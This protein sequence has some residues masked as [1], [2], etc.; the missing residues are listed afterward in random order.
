MVPVSIPK[1]MLASRLTRYLWLFSALLT[2]PLLSTSTAHRAFLPPASRSYRI[3]PL[4]PCFLLIPA[5]LVVS[6]L[7]I[8]LPLFLPL[9][10]LLA[11][12]RPCSGLSRMSLAAFS[13]ISTT[14]APHPY[15]VSGCVLL[16]RTLQQSFP[17]F[18]PLGLELTYGCESR[19]T[20]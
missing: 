10:P 20:C 2:L 1:S 7:S 11:M 19:H 8:P 4:P 16:T 5:L 9:S 3:P 13:S 6:F 15:L 14:E 12:F 18:T 17:H